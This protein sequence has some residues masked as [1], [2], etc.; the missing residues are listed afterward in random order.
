MLI[1][2]ES[3]SR[4]AFCAVGMAVFLIDWCVFKLLVLQNLNVLVARC[5]ALIV[6]IQFTFVGQRYFVVAKSQ[7]ENVKLLTAWLR[8]QVSSCFTTLLSFSLFALLNL[9]VNHVFFAFSCAIFI[10]TI[11]NYVLIKHWIYR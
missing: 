5:I 6:A 7:L 4:V 1:S 9:L 3:M 2:V 11:T 8:H 10:S